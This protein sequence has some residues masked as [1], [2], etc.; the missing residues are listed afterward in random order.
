MKQKIKDFFKEVARILKMPEMG[1]LPGQLAFYFVL[2]IVPTIS[3]LSYLATLLNV[4]SNF[5]FNFLTNAFSDE[6]SNLIVSN[7][8]TAGSLNGVE[9]L[10]ILII[11]YFIASNGFNSIIVTSNTIYGVKSK[12]MLQR[13]LKALIMTLM[14]FFLLIFILLIPVFGDRIILLI[15]YMDLNEVIANR[16]TAII[17]YL[18][19]PISWFVIFL[20]TK[21]IYTM[22]PDRKVESRKVN[23]GAIFTTIMWVIGTV[24]Y[25]FYINNWSRFND[26]YG[27]LANVMILM[28]WFYYLAF[29]FTVGMALNYHKEEEELEKTEALKKTK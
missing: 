28:L 18:Q 4:N 7:T 29:I 27:A 5:I 11:A 13:R 24:I 26:F 2:A 23:Y 25:S 15:Q 3:L 14:M 19:G 9:F 10:I 20:I 8:F 1:I 22:A 6:V 12:N 16:I 17:G 21:L